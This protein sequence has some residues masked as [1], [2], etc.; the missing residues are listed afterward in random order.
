[1]LPV[2]DA[3]GGVALITADHG[4][5][6][7]MF[8]LDKKTHEAKHNKDGSVKAKTSHTL[9]Q[10]PFILY[11]NVSGKKLGLNNLPHAGLSNIASTISNLIGLEPHEK[12]DPSLL[13]IG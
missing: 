8:E 6:D 2:L 10:V 9:N 1:V 4:N 3:M 12:W 7:E 13:K 11:D 5:C